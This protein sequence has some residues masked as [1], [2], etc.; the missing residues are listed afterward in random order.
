MAKTARPRHST[1]ADTSVAVDAFM[2]D[3]DHPHVDA[4]QRLRALVLGVD[5][6]VAEGIKWN[7]PSWR[8]TEY[9]ATT[10]LRATSGIGLVLHRGAKARALPDGGLAIDDLDGLLTWPSPD[11]ALLAFANRDDIEARADAV[12]TLLRQ[13]IA[14]V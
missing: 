13:W 4:V 7:A 1:P 10:Q 11:R 14:H 12:Q 2:A 6:T 5:P 3:L 9:F 8:T